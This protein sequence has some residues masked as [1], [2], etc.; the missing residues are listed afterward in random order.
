MAR[1]VINSYMVR[2]PLGGNLSWALQWLIGL[3]R[4]GHDVYVVEKSGYPDACFDLAQGRMTDDCTYGVAV[5]QALLARFD[6]KDRWCYLDARGQYRGLP[7]PEVEAVLGSADLFLDMGTHG[8]DADGTWLDEATTARRR[9]LVA[10]EPGLTQMRMELKLT[11]GDT[12]PEYD[13]YYTTGLNLGTAEST[14]PTA[15]RRWWPIFDPVVTDLFP[16]LPK[17]P[18][19]PFTTVMNWQSHQPVR[20]G[21]VEYGYKERE[22]PKFVDLPARTRVA[23]ELAVAG[24]RAPTEQLR[25]AGWR[26]RDAHQVT[27]SFDAYQAYIAASR[28]EFGVCKQVCVA[29]NVGWFSDRS[30]AYLASGRPVVM[31]ET[32]FSRHLPCG[33]GL[34]AVRTVE[35]AA[36]AIEEIDGEWE[37]HAQWARELASEY[38]EAHK[39]L[40]RM[41]EHL[42]L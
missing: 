7:R 2:Y 35:E 33:R 24:K 6:L 29:S 39:V 27:V 13:V 26:V 9:V 8:V 25:A 34:F 4:L 23:L 16:V 17:P 28:G 19:A 31:Q 18:R 12:L 21:G 10:T 1:I 40:G 42:G 20:F 14:A 15:G 37:R 11:A 41:L 3:K 38:L 5:V 32:G 22:F 30:A 36:A